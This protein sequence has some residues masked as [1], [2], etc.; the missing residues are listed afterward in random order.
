MPMPSPHAKRTSV[1]S[2]ACTRSCRGLFLALIVM[3]LGGWAGCSPTEDL[4]TRRTAPNVLLVTVDTLR[5]DRLG[6]YGYPL[7][8]TPAI[9]ELAREGVRFV[10]CTVQWPKTWPSMASLMSG[11]YPRSTGMLL[12]RT[13]L[14]RGIPLLAGVFADAGYRTAA[15][16]ANYNVGRTFGFDRGFEHF[17]E[18]W[19]ERWEDQQGS[20]PFENWSGRVKLYTDARLVN[21]QALRWLQSG[22]AGQDGRPFFLWLHYMDP[23]GPYLTPPG[24]ERRFRGA[25]PVQEVGVDQLPAYQRLTNAQT[26]AVVNDLGEYVARYDGLVSF[27]DEELGRLVAEVK[28]TH[29][30][31]DLVVV[32]TADHGESLGEHGYYLEHGRLPYQPSGH[33]PLIV[34]APER[35]PAGRVVAD[36][37]GLLDLS[38]TLL[39]LAELEVPPS[40]EGHS[41]LAS[42]RAEPGARPPP[43]VFMESGESAPSQLT[44]REGS[45]KLVRVQSKTDRESMAGAYHELYDLAA[46]PA[47]LRNVARLHPDVVGRLDKVLEDWLRSRPVPSLPAEGVDLQSLDPKALEMLRTLGYVE[48]DER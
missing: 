4:S 30:E 12:E 39:E 5:A 21:E 1:S 42:M 36:P 24:Y 41:L 43:H 45:W 37:V 32:V 25:H 46:D 16:V 11:A 18:S 15:I 2:V 31:R 27:L 19:Q 22:A 44:V 28:G 47:E 10:D 13:V 9:D 14:P 48:G 3:G 35:L 6:C 29:T 17:V 38:R 23:H 34:W 7:G 33:V 20:T 26:G 40:F 8:T